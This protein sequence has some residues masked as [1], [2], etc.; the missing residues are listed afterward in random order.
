MSKKMNVL[1]LAALMVSL[2][3]ST[4]VT[5][6]ETDYP[7][8]FKL[9]THNVYMLSQN[10]YPNWG[11]V[12][13]AELISKADYIKNQDVVILNEIFDNEASNKLLNG[14]S[15]QYPYQTP[16]LGRSKN[17][18]DKTLGS[19]SN[20]TP[21]DGGVAI[22]SKWPIVEKV[23]YVYSEGCGADWFS[24]KGFVY[25]KINKNGHFYHVV[26]THMQSEDERCSVG[27][28]ASVRKSQMIEMKEFI[29]KKNI[30]A[31]EVVYIAGDM[32]VIKD[33]AE[34]SSMLTN[35]NVKEPSDYT[36][37]TSTWDPAT[38]GIAGY[39]YPNLQPQYLDYIFVEKSHKQPSSWFV[40][41]LNVKSP[42]W[43]VTSLGKSYSYTDYSDHYPVSGSSTP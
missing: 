43:T 16:V 29:T 34:Y 23:Q 28:D 1:V 26:G 7:N 18:W 15:T 41:A 13:R 27:K 17:N 12:Q 35:L 25:V 3:I 14:L 10:L 8:D 4:N 37:F 36:G 2:M 33:T 24:N 22:I 31:D 19:Y 5:A 20:L 40:N 32:N 6:E 42:E 21:E 9:L 11:Q 38:N 30:P 39:N